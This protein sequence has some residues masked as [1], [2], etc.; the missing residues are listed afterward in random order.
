LTVDGRPLQPF[1]LTACQIE[2]RLCM[3]DVAGA[4]VRFGTLLDSSVWALI[5]TDDRI[6]RLGLR[7]DRGEDALVGHLSEDLPLLIQRLLEKDPNEPD[8]YRVKNLNW[9]W[10]DWLLGRDGGQQ[11]AAMALVALRDCFG[12]QPR[13][14]RNLLVHGSDQLVDL[15]QVER[16]MRSAGLI[17][18]VGQPFGTNCLS[19]PKVAGLLSRLG[20][21]DLKAAVGGHLQDVLRLVVDG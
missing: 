18:A 2:V 17:D 10:P 5:G 4:L 21:P 9:G 19:T 1:A 20:A 7:A 3:G 12:G 15:A 11:D 14:F 6:R 16:A 8:R 13:R